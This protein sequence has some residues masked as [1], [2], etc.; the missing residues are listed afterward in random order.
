M[1]PY[2]V[3]FTHFGQKKNFR[4]DK[5]NSP[6]ID[7]L[8]S[9]ENIKNIKNVLIYN[10]FKQTNLILNKDHQSNLDIANELIY[11]YKQLTNPH[12]KF[13]EI[14]DDKVQK[15]D[16]TTIIDKINQIV[17]KNLTIQIIGEVEFFVNNLNVNY[18]KN[19]R[20]IDSIQNSKSSNKINTFIQ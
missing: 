19:G 18:A 10:A 16:Y 9:D 2:S 20:R 6:L 1:Q 17:I 14:L 8:L 4:M 7:M 11:T 5:T 15:I 12:Q 3:H 13:S